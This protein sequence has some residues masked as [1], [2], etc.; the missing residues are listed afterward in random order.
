[1][2]L[3]SWCD[4]RSLCTQRVFGRDWQEIAAYEYIKEE[5]LVDEQDTD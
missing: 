4:Y 2:R 1:M 3:C 5:R